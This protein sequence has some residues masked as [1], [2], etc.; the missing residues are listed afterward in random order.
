MECHHAHAHWVFWHF[1]AANGELL[2]ETRLQLPGRAARNPVF[3][4]SAVVAS[5]DLQRKK[6]RK[7]V[8]KQRRWHED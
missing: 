1:L 4:I 7:S 5:I 3:H 2:L 8:F 6:E